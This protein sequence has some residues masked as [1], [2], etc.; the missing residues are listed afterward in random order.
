MKKNIAII[1]P[2]KNE[3]DNL[4]KLIP[5]LQALYPEIKVNI[6]NVTNGFCFLFQFY[7][8]CWKVHPQI[9]SWYSFTKERW[10]VYFYSFHRYLH[11][12]T[13]GSWI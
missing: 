8:W 10:L 2:A 9:S 12:L 4:D 7:Q 13:G 1:I 3:A 5:E 6:I 11:C